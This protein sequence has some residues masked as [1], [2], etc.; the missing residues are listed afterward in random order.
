M[1]NKEKL[2]I[3]FLGAKRIPS[4]EGGIEVVVE[5]LATGMAKRGHEVT[6][7][8]R[9]GH[10][11]S[12][13]EF[14]T[15]KKKRFKHKGVQV[16]TVPTVD[17]RGLAAVTSS[18]FATVRAVFG[19]YDCIHYHAEG[20]CAWIWI[21]HFLGIR[22]VATIHGLDWQRSKWGGFATQY[23]QFGEKMAAEYADEVIVLS[24]NVQQYFLDTY[25]RETKL[26]PNGVG[27]HEKFP[28]EEI[29][30]K[31]GLEKD[32]YICYLSRIVPEK[33][34]SYLIDA[35][36]AVD[37]DKKLV[38]AG[39]SSDTEDFYREMQKKAAD[40]PRIIFTGFVQGRIRRELYSNAYLYVL[41]SDLEGMPLTLLEA[42]SYGNCCLVSDIDE[43]TEVVEDK[44]VIFKKGD[45]NDLREKLQALCDDAEKVAMYKNESADFICDRYNWDDVIEETLKL[46]R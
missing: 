25:G 42:M 23:L 19:G 27:R 16:V 46:Y 17:M 36:K 2:R 43:C 41:P 31:F 15:E 44:A 38:V 22:T 7:Y 30:K 5:K 20:P 1:R 26:I 33:G 24:K 4:R 45:V 13:K 14:D 10:H 29:N 9:D 11:V 35:F 32:S 34:L 12:G 6:V 18:F 21:P 37:T 8:N 40:D 39:G 28:A 3:G